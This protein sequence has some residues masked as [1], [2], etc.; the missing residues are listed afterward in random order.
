MLA[1]ELGVQE[2]QLHR[3]LDRLDLRAQAADVR[4]AD[5]RDLLQ[6]QL[7]HLLA[8]DELQGHP[9]AGV[10]RD[11]LARARLGLAQ[12]AGHAQDAVVAGASAHDQP[13]GVKDLLDR[14]Q[15][16]RLLVAQH[17]DHGRVLVHEHLATGLQLSR[18]GDQRRDGAAHE[19]PG[20]VDVS[21]Q[22]RRA[23]RGGRR[24]H[25]HQSGDRQRDLDLVGQELLELL[26]LAAGGLQGGAQLLVLI[27]GRGQLPVQ[28]ALLVPD[29]SDLPTGGGQRM[30]LRR[31]VGVCSGG[32][33]G[34]RR[35]SS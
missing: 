25:A 2:G 24:D 1:V 11:H 27:A 8:L 17:G 19:P 31:A 9:V 18:R 23:H 26:D 13:G 15:L 35:R 32:R 22:G 4:V 7:L 28:I 10:D 16:A 12:G 34:H 30:V 21:G 3:V 20:D 5:V 33:F 29:Q 6:D 14:C